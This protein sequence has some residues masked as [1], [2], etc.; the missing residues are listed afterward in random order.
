LREKRIGRIEPANPEWLTQGANKKGSIREPVHDSVNA[1][2][3]EDLAEVDEQP[4]TYVA[5]AKVGEKLLFVHRGDLFNGLQFDDNLVFHNEVSTK[6][7]IEMDVVVDDGN[8]LLAD[9]VKASKSQFM[10]QD[11]LINRFEEPWAKSL[12]NVEGGINDVARDII[13]GSVVHGI[14]SRRK[15]V[16]ESSS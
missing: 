8:G 14:M 10:G 11:G 15:T 1:V 2:F 5:Q 16:K 3:D 4:E 7:F 9:D 12:V 6:A 13:F